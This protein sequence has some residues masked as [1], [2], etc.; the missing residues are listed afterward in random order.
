MPAKDRRIT[1][2]DIIPMEQFRAQRSER[3]KAMLPMKKLRR[4]EVGPH[5]TFYFETF[6]T[7]LFQVQEMQAIEKGGEEQLKDELAAYNPMI[8]QGSELTATIMF[9]IDDPRRRAAI[10][11]RL[12]GVEKRFFIQ[13]GDTRIAGVAEGDVERTDEETGK[14]SSVHFTHFPVSETQKKL[15]RDPAMQVMAGVDHEH[16]GHVAILSPATRA[17]LAKDFS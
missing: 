15:F 4:V 16:Y 10:L 11:A 12:G 9:E 13:V 5:C 6:E 2:A 3:R 7:M 17:E 14:A 1:S 8:P